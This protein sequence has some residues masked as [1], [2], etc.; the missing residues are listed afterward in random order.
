MIEFFQNIFRKDSAESSKRFFGGIG[1]A[2]CI[3]TICIY[4]QEYL[5]ELLYTSAAL[6]GLGMFDKAKTNG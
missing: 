6:L 1:M 3:V 4:K 5:Q 2:A